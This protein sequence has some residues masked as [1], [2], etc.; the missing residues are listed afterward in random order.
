LKNINKFD[1]IVR[2]PKKRLDKDDVMYFLAQKFEANRKYSENEVNNII[3]KH[4]LFNDVP[5]LRRELIS[6]KLLNR[7]DDGSLYWKL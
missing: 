7:T 2:W 6:R 3:I 5:L 4:H 1:E